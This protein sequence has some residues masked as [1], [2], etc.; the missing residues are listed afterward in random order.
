GVAL[1]RQ[2][3]R[4]AG[5]GGALADDQRPLARDKR[6]VPDP[7]ARHVGDRVP[8]AGREPP[9]PDAEVARPRAGAL[10]RWPLRD[11]R[12]STS[13]DALVRGCDARFCSRGEAVAPIAIRTSS[14]PATASPLLSI[15][16]LVRN[17]VSCYVI[18]QDVRG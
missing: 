14:L 12:H 18:T 3:D 13:L 4:D 9:D 2:D 7:H 17:H 16:P 15:T 11:V 8:A 5:A 10:R 6:R 1:V